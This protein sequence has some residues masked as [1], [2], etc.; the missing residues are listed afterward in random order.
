MADHAD[1]PV[2]GLE[3]CEHLHRHLERLLVEAAEALVDQE[4]VDPPRPGMRLDGLGEPERKG[5]SGAEALAAREGSGGARLP[6]PRV[7]HL[8]VEADRGVG[9]L[10][11]LA[12]QQAEPAR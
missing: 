6:H 9:A 7:E 8:D 2:S 4:R 1:E 3:P 12:L 10:R 5:K 11:L